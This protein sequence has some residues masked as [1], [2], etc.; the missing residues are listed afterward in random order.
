VGDYRHALRPYSLG[1]GYVNF[2]SDV[3]QGS[4]PQIYR[5][6]H[7]RLARVKRRHDPVNLFRLNQNDAP[8]ASSE[9]PH[10]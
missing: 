3:E 6:N 9:P 8:A 2:S 1:A 4:A 10:T 7:E 5:R